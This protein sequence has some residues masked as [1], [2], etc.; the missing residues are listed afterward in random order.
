[1]S[2][3]RIPQVLVETTTRC[4][5][6]FLLSQESGQGLVPASINTLVASVSR[7]LMLATASRAIL[8]GALA[9]LCIGLGVGLFAT[10]AKEQDPPPT[11]VPGTSAP[12]GMGSRP[13]AVVAPRRTRPGEMVEIRGRVV[14]PGGQA[15]LGARIVLDPK[16]HSIFGEEFDIPSERAVSG[17]D[18]R[19]SFEIARAEIAALRN[20][21]H[22]LNPPVY[23]AVAPGRGT[24]WVDIPPAESLAHKLV[25][26]LTP[27]DIPI[28][29]R[30]LDQQGRP[31]AGVRASAFTIAEPP[32]RDVREFLRRARSSDR[33]T[34]ANAWDELRSC[35]MLGF[36]DRT[37]SALSD[38]NGEF[39]LTGVGRDRLV[40]LDLHGATVAD[41]QVMVMTTS[42]SLEE[43]ISYSP[44][45]S[46]IYR[47]HRPRFELR[48][49]PG[50][51]LAGTIRDRETGEALAGIRVLSLHEGDE[52]ASMAISDAQGRYRLTGQP[53]SASLRINIDSQRLPFFSSSRSVAIP[54]GTGPVMLDLALV[55]GVV[56]EGRVTNRLSGRPVRARVGY[57]PLLDNPIFKDDHPA[58]SKDEFTSMVGTDLNGHFRLV[59]L[60]GSGLLAVLAQE[61]G[62]LTA[63]PPGDE[64]TAQI[65]NPQ[66]FEQN[67]GSASKQYRRIEI[68]G[69]VKTITA[70]TRSNALKTLTQDF[71][72]E[73]GHAVKIL[74]D[75]PDSKPLVSAQPVKADGISVIE[76]PGDGPVFDYLHENPG[77]S[78]T[79]L[80]LDRSRKLGGAVVVDGSEEQ[81]IHLALRPTGTVSGRL[82]D[83]QGRPRAHVLLEVSAEGERNGNPW[84]Y[85][86]GDR[87]LTAADGT[88]V[89]TGVIP[90]IL[91]ALVWPGPITG[92]PARK[93]ISRPGNGRS[94]PANR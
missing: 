12:D 93:A 17:P 54:P 89:I 29:G 72:L 79:L 86:H 77:K 37:P 27:D 44:G 85:N 53:F 42:E 38:A 92:V 87:V 91:T 22:G 41:S 43:A 55:R 2:Y 31:L 34:Q 39:R 24:A 23:A 3:V 46:H 76:R 78:D 60:P 32:N 66:G 88:F 7:G 94:N 28:H 65:A 58:T 59:A 21:G 61:R 62:Y 52:S 49:P 19:F 56:I 40:L 48:L 33:E 15:V 45:N 73:P 26:Q 30:L 69:T 5:S 20:A 63:P 74:V 36:Y 84:Q 67:F 68:P 70:Y 13:Q 57:F 11:V 83:E 10:K 9:F 82:V 51:E 81:T 4:V 47:V 64:L 8:A 25:L 18:G 50:R 16:F 71:P 35:V 14:D 1:M 75:G 90:E 80:F 6:Q